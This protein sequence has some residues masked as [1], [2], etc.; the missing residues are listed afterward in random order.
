MADVIAKTTGEDFHQFFHQ[1]AVFRQPVESSAYELFGTREYLDKGVGLTLF[2]RENVQGHEPLFWVTPVIRDSQWDMLSQEEKKNMH[3]IAYQWYDTTIEKSQTSDYRYLKEAVDHALESN[4]IR[5]A[6]R[7]AIVLGK[8]LGDLLL[9]KDK[10]DLLQ[11]IYERITDEII[12][13][14]VERKR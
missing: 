10:R 14:A 3:R 9:Y 2:E 5:G 12:R 13:E 8:Y 11:K 7:H 1:A 6:C 4:N